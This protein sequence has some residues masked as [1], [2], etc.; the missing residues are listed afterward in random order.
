MVFRAAVNH[1]EIEIVGINDL[2]SAD[3]LAYM[4]KY[5]TMHGQ[6]KGEVSSTDKAIVV[7][8]TGTS[9]TGKNTGGM[10][11][12]GSSSAPP[13][14]FL[15]NIPA[16][17]APPSAPRRWGTALKKLPISCKKKLGKHW[18][19]CIKYLLHKLLEKR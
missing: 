8:D 18:Q 17:G 9:T 10:P 14:S 19:I 1:P 4:L 5:D 7:L 11:V 13:S 16:A 2:C 6:F 12:T 3:Y 15:R